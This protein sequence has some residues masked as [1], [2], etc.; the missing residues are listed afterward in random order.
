MRPLLQRDISVEDFINYY[1]LKD[2]LQHFCRAYG[3]SASGSKV[4]L[5]NRIQHFLQTGEIVKPERKSRIRPSLS[6]QNLTLQTII[7]ENHRCSQNVRHF[8]KQ[9]I[10]KFHFSTYIQ[11]YFKE[12]VGKTYADVMV[13]WHEEQKRLKDPNYTKIIAPQF[14]YNQFT[15]DYFQDPAN[16]GKTKRDAID[17]WN[18]IKAQP[19]P[20]TYKPR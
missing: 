20:N 9:H 8:F 4:D 16:N 15:R 12:N 2:E 3:L 7:T 10:P 18:V 13:A 1:W 11:N 6:E 5:T 17:A 14:E 19:G